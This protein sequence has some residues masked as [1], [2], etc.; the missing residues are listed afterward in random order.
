MSAPPASSVTVTAGPRAQAQSAWPNVHA[1]S[2]LTRR[3]VP[4]LRS[5]TKGQ[6]AA[7]P[8]RTRAIPC[9]VLHRAINVQLARGAC[10]Q[11][12]ILKVSPLGWSATSAGMICP[13][14]K[15]IVQPQA[16]SAPCGICVGRGAPVDGCRKRHRRSHGRQACGRRSVNRRLSLRWF[17]PNTCHTLRKRS[18]SCVF[19]AIRA[20]FFLSCRVSPCRA[21]GPCVA[22]STTHSGRDSCPRTVGVHR[23]FSTDGRGPAAPVACFGLT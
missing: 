2:R 15:L 17:E 14:P 10:S 9:N 21:V 5:E 3:P 8:D 20:V 11:S 16:P 7:C 1:K 13:I 6:A 19:S 22:V 4:T 23:R 12:R 18:A